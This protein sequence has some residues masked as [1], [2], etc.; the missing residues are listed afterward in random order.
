MVEAD[1]TTEKHSSAGR[2]RPSMGGMM[3][4]AGGTYTESSRS[5]RRAASGTSPSAPAAYAEEGDQLKVKRLSSRE[6]HGST[7]ISSTARKV[8]SSSTAR[9]PVKRASKPDKLPSG[10]IP[11]RTS[12]GCKRTTSKDSNSN[13]KALLHTVADPNERWTCQCGHKMRI[14][15]NFCGM[16]A[17]PKNWT[18]ENCGFDENECDFNYCGGCASPKAVQRSHSV[19]RPPSIDSSTEPS[20]A[21]STQGQDIS[22]D[23][24]LLRALE[25]ET[26]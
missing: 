10:E 1:G 3:V 5:L 16:C 11:K 8:R 18:C 24:V 9:N 2:R 12:S 15:M 4:E 6:K 23:S 19:S 25:Y 20:T 13:C 17:A 7:R 22:Q 21:E 14:C 26:L